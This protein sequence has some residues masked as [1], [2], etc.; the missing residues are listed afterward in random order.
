MSRDLRASLDKQEIHGRDIE[1]TKENI[2]SLGRKLGEVFTQQHD[3]VD[4]LDF[5]N[6]D[7]QDLRM[8]VKS[9]EEMCKAHET[10]QNEIKKALMKVNERLDK[11]ERAQLEM[12]TEL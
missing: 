2:F 9:T 10:D 3:I 12:S 7:L 11:L 4:A 1:K 6:H 5:N 8:R